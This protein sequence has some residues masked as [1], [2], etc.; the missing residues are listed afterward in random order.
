MRITIKEI[1]DVAS[2]HQTMGGLQS[3]QDF[4]SIINPPHDE[5]YFA[6]KKLIAYLE[7][8][9]YEKILELETL[10]VFGREWYY[11]AQFEDDE[12]LDEYEE[13]EP[14]SIDIVNCFGCFQEY[15]GKP[16][17]KSDAIL[18]LTAKINLAQ[19]LRAAL[20]HCNPDEITLPL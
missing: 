14:F 1:K 15:V 5:Y 8:L 12:E 11:H 2:L 9:E 19:Y 17:G 6:R 18:Y 13:E 20:Q 7:S 10:M 3:P 16:E 4:S